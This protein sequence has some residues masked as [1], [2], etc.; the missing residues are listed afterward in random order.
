MYVNLTINQLILILDIR[1]LSFSDLSFS[2]SS[3][4]VS[5]H[6]FNLLVLGIAT[7]ERL[8]V[9]TEDVRGWYSNPYWPGDNFEVTK[10]RN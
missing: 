5:G 6:Q 7:L 2:P 10:V 3:N 8:T 1:F 9:P 4:R